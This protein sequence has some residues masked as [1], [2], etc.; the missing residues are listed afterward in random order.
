MPT[1]PIAENTVGFAQ[2]TDHKI[3]APNVSAGGEMVGRALQG[4]GDQI[5]N[6][7]QT[8]QVISDAQDNAATKAAANSVDATAN[9][10]LFTGANPYFETQGKGALD[11]RAPTEKS[12]DEAIAN[13]RKGL[14]TPK[15][16]EMFDESVGQRRL[17][18][19][20]RI[21][22]HAH[23]QV[24]KWDDDQTEA[25]IT[26]NAQSAVAN[27][28]NPTE[29]QTYIDA[30]LGD[31]NHRAVLNRWSPDVTKV[32]KLKF[33]SG[34]HQ[35]IGKQLITEGG[36]DGPKLGLAYAEQHKPDLTGAGYDE[37]VAR[38]KV[39]QNALD[40]D[41][42]RAEAEARRE[43]HEVIREA[44]DRAQSAVTNLDSG[45]PLKP[46]E[47]ASALTDAKTTGDPALVHHLEVGQQ[48]NSLN[49]Q[50][51]GATPGELQAVVS[52]D[53]A[54]IAQAGVNAKPEWIVEHDHL[55][56]LLSSS[57][58]QLA[59]DPYE[60]AAAHKG[61]NVPK[62]NLNDPNSVSQR[63]ATANKIAMM[64]GTTPKPF[65]QDEIASSQQTLQHGDVNAK[66]GLAMRIARMGPLAMDGAEQLTNNSGFINLIGLASHSNHGIGVQRVNQVVTGYEVLKTKPK[67]IDKDRA[68]AQFN[69]YI[70]GS[71]QFLPQVRDGVLSNAQALL[72]TEANEHGWDDWGKAQGRWYAAVNSA[73]GSYPRN[74]V[75]LGGLAKVNGAMT[76]LPENMS[77]GDFE[78]VISKS[79]ATEFKRGANGTPVYSDGRAATATDIKRMQ[80]VPSGDGIYRMSDGNAFLHRKEGGFFEIDISKVH[81][82]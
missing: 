8:L 79:G 35:E 21:A 13:A 34:V 3:E 74:G 1:V 16:L 14:K 77:Q 55:Q 24:F 5:G 32:E 72:A 53:A 29:S 45:I 11:A 82:H 10:I 27:H 41:Q 81:S 2:T 71:L 80:W 62:L 65:T 7:V 64:T 57:R 26:I 25:S 28:L 36:A 56:G 78:N 68:T 46:D 12:L 23:T 37:I 75:Q 15:Q 69:Q 43:E 73:L 50:Y 70:G 63:I 44:R 60:W 39:E 18:W 67:L 30:G 54:K 58:A 48:K 42:R 6:T 76:V 52:A 38:A 47:M 61:I 9:D 59:R 33:T 49:I 51:R 40:A 66:V 17:S 19:G 31:I 20:A 4:F 22:D